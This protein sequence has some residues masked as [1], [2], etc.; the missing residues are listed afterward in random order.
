MK[1]SEGQLPRYVEDRQAFDSDLKQRKGQIHDDW[2]IGQ[3]AK[4]TDKEATKRVKSSVSKEDISK[5]QRPDPDLKVIRTW[6]ENDLK[7]D[8][9]EISRHGP[10]VKGYWMQWDS[11]HLRDDLITRKWE[12]SD[13]TE[14]VCL[15]NN[16]AQFLQRECAARTT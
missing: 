10:T 4:V 5:G 1:I 11:L 13:G 12:S 15:P 16:S 3:I 2:R 8:W 14:Q 9:Q 7:P 6:L